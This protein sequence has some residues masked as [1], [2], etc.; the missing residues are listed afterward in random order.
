ME[1]Y[2]NFFGIVYP[3]S[4][5]DQMFSP[6]FNFGAMENV[7]LVTYMKNILGKINHLNQDALVF[8]TQS[9]MN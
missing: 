7:G 4:K 3:F 5:Y 6:E 9:F 2:Y 1:W 8:A